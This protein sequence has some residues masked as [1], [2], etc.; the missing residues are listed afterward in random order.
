M[1][2]LISQE[3]RRIRM[4]ALVLYGSD[5]PID[6]Y[7]QLSDSKFVKIVNKVSANLEM[8]ARYHKKGVAFVYIPISDFDLFT[9]SVRE[10]LGKRLKKISTDNSEPAQEI[11][12]IEDKARA[13][14]S[15]QD[16]MK[17][18]VNTGN[19][20][21]ES[22]RLAHDICDK[23]FD[24]VTTTNVAKYFISFKKNCSEEFLHATVV[25]F[26]ACAMI[27]NFSW[28]NEEIKKKVTLAAIL[29]DMTLTP[30][31]FVILKKSKGDKDRL[32]PKILNHPLEIAEIIEKHSNFVSAETLTIIKQHHERPQGKGFPKSLNHQSI[33]ALTSVYI[34]AHYFV[35][36][37]F[38]ENYIDEYQ[39]ERM[40]NVVSQMKERF[41]AGIYKKSWES[42]NKLFGGN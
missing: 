3:L 37:M 33:S 7:I 17:A 34:V 35:D 2:E 39:K 11:K 32:S 23:T 10:Q 20:N 41:S 36:R 25:S 6:A 15:A 5:H 31:D 42:L 40:Q 8:L 9:N 38:D 14:S 22:K 19:I 28:G 26:I 18:I 21:D 12:N 27:D 1:S 24:M 4:E 30:E 29:C 13:L 16:I